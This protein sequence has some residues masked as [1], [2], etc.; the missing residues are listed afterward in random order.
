MDKQSTL[1]FVLMGLYYR[2]Q[3]QNTDNFDAF[4]HTIGFPITQEDIGDTVGL[5]N[6]HVNRVM[7]ELIAEKLITCH[8]KKLCILDEKKLSE[9]ADFNPD[10][11][12]G[13]PLI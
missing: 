3:S 11:I 13:H 7:K 6:V 2:V 10:M 8:K 12:T 1:A 9:I 4:T 5:T